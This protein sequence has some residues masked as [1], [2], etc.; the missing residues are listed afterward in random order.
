MQNY[1]DLKVWQKAHFL[2]MKIYRLTKDFPKEEQFNLTS[3]LRRAALS[4]PTNIAE[5]AGKFSNKD[6][7]RFLQIAL[8]SANE[9]DYLTLF[10]HDLDIINESEFKVLTKEIGEIKGML[11]S[12]IKKVRSKSDSVLKTVDL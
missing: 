4:I 12:L 2:A 3:Q 7:A 10:S 5:G 1:K 9:V 11:I 6:F 8:G